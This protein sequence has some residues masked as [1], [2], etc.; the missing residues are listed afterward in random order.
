MKLIYMLNLPVL[1]GLLFDFRMLFSRNPSQK[2]SH[3]KY[4]NDDLIQSDAEVSSLIESKK[5]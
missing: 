3:G 4:R 1:S 5:E 2:T